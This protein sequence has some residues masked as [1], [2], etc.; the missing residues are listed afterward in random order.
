MFHTAILANAQVTNPAEY[1]VD[2]YQIEC[3][4]ITPDGRDSFAVPAW[5][6]KGLATLAGPFKTREEAQAALDTEISFWLVD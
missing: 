4:W 2:Y 3:P 5:E 1:G 6:E